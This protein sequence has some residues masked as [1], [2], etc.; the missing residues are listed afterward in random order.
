MFRQ[1]WVFIQ[2]YIILDWAVLCPFGLRRRAD[3]PHYEAIGEDGSRP[4]GF[5]MQHKKLY[6]KLF[7]G[8][9]A[10]I[11]EQGQLRCGRGRL[12]RRDGRA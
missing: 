1:V 6:T 8:G 12:G 10:T 2:R 9:T 3:E 5:V 11:V 7:L 4:Q